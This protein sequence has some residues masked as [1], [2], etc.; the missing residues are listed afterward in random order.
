MNDP[1]SDQLFSALFAR[2]R[3]GDAEALSE[4][5]RTYESEVRIVAH[6][7]LGPALR[8]HLDSLDL[9]Q[10]VHRSLMAGLRHEKFDISTPENLVA[11][12]LTIV[13]RKVAKKWRQVQRQERL[14]RGPA[15]DDDL[16]TTLASLTSREGD[17]AGA[18][19]VNDALRRVCNDL[20][21]ADR[22]L[23]ELRLAG[24]TTAEAARELGTDPDVLRA[25][26]SRLRQ[27]LRTAG[28]L[29]E[30]M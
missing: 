8:P 18:A 12:A 23:M 26:L 2:A 9:V 13:R 30:W 16:F 6:V 11:L 15:G 24:Y 20:T 10:S 27:H 4:L 25:H 28:I 29:S 19:E 21:P 14:T 7:L 1:A 22:R 3:A 17:P 5:V